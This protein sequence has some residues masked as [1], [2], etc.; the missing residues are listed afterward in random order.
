MRKNE[1][2]K[3]SKSKIKIKQQNKMEET[4]IERW[5]LKKAH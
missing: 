2:M 4:G 5:F 3:K 1:A